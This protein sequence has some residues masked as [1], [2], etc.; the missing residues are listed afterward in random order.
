MTFIIVMSCVSLSLGI[1]IG[2]AAAAL[3]DVVELIC[4]QKIEKKQKALNIFRE[5]LNKEIDDI[6]KDVK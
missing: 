6:I 3:Q 2:I 1:L 5:N 4:Q